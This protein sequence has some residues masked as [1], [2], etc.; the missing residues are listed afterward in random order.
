MLA[1]LRTLSSSV[2]L[3]KQ[4]ISVPIE[5]TIIKLIQLQDPRYWSVWNI[6]RRGT[7]TRDTHHC[8]WLAVVRTNWL[9]T[10]LETTGSVSSI[11]K[12]QSWLSATQNIL[13]TRAEPTWP[14]TSDSILTG[15]SISRIFNEILSKV[16]H[17]SATISKKATILDQ[18]LRNMIIECR[19]GILPDGGP[20][21]WKSILIWNCSD[22]KF[23]RLLISADTVEMRAKR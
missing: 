20:T 9:V 2:S 3:F 22:A 13:L 4:T 7:T 8:Y 21:H 16:L 1:V 23:S 6:R 14:N 10:S 17:L 12:V 18:H 11:L 19:L 15:R 5:P